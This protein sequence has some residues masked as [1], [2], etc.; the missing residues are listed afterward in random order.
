VIHKTIIHITETLARGGAETLL[1]GVV[2]SLTDYEHIIISLKSQNAFEEDLANIRII[3]FN[4][5][6][7]SSIP[8]LVLKLKRFFKNIQGDVIVHAHMFWAN[9]LSRLAVP[10]HLP[11]INSYH[12]V[13]YGPHGANYPLHAVLLDRLTYNKRVTTLC[14]SHEVKRNVAAYVGIK[15]NVTVL[16]NY[17]SDAFFQH[18][19]PATKLS[20]PLKI[21]SV[22]NL[23]KQKNY[24][25]IV[26][27][28]AI[29]KERSNSQVYSLDVYGTGPL[30]QSLQ[31]QITA[32]GIDNIFFRGSVPDVAER[33]PGY[34]VY[35]LSSSYE[36]FGIAVIEA[37][38]V[39]LPLLLSDIQVLREITGNNALFFDPHK[40]EELAKTIEQ[41]VNGRVEL[42]AL[43]IKGMEKAETYRKEYYMK[44]LSGIYESV[45]N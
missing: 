19:R 23:K 22:G 20:S 28:F 39:G 8:G 13:S 45:I 15:S 21:V 41:V 3:K 27:A 6:G 12:S 31:Q 33:L 25:T 43:S 36:G 7:Y 11:L 17:I 44:K 40:P 30:L 35:L 10:E 4:L 29:L 26:T 38:A 14:V 32:A 34:D 1:V 9:V 24:E 2:K 5:K 16:Y 37:M 18:S 42:S